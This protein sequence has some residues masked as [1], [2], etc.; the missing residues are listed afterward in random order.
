MIQRL[1]VSILESS[2][3]YTLWSAPLNRPKVD[4]IMRMLSRL[5]IKRASILDIGCG[6]GTNSSFFKDWDYLGIDIN[7]LYIEG[8]KKKYPEMRFET[9]DAARLTIQGEK[10]DVILIN[11]MMHHLD[12]R[13]CDQLLDGIRPLL[14]IGGAVIVQEPITPTKDERIMNTLMRQDRG[15]YFRTLDAWKELFGR[16]RYKIGNDEFYDIKL[17]KLVVGWHMYSATLTAESHF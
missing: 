13:E 9:G 6:P 8:A 7:P 16:N 11:S 4:A 14:A 1:K 10:F 17:A 3:G 2:L 12:D 15:D 5:G